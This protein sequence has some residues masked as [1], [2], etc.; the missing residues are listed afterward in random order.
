MVFYISYDFTQKKS[1][2]LNDTNKKQ[3]EVEESELYSEESEDLSEFDHARI[4]LGFVNPRK[5]ELS[6]WKKQMDFVVKHDLIDTW[7]KQYCCTE[8]RVVADEYNGDIKGMLTYSPVPAAEFVSLCIDKSNFHIHTAAQ[9]RDVLYIILLNSLDRHPYVYQLYRFTR[10]WIVRFLVNSAIFLVHLSLG[11][12]KENTPALLQQH[13]TKPWILMAEGVVLFIELFE[14]ISAIIILRT[15]KRGHQETYKAKIA[16]NGVEYNEYLARTVRGFMKAKYL[17][18]L[19]RLSF[20]L[21][22]LIIVTLDWLAIM[23]FSWSIEYY[24][25]IRVL[26]PFFLNEAI[27]SV[28]RNFWNTIRG[29]K[30]EFLLYFSSVVFAAITA[31]I[32]FRTTL[33]P[34]QI[35]NSYRNIIRSITTSFVFFSTGENYTELVYSAFETNPLYV[36]YYVSVTIM[37]SFIVGAFVLSSFVS[38]FTLEFQSEMLKAKH[39]Q[40]SGLIASFLLLDVSHTSQ[41]PMKVLKEFYNRVNPAKAHYSEDYLLKYRTN[42]SEFVR[43]CRDLRSFVEAMEDLIED[44]RIADYNRRYYDPRPSRR[45]SNTM[46]CDHRDDM[47]VQVGHIEPPAGEFFADF[48]KDQRIKQQKNKRSSSL[49]SAAV[50]IDALGGAIGRKRANLKAKVFNMIG[51]QITAQVITFFVILQAVLL[52][53]Y[54]LASYDEILD[55]FNVCLICIYALELIIKLYAFGLKAYLTPTD[56]QFA[57]HSHF[58]LPEY[59]VANRIDFFAIIFSVGSVL[60]AIM[61]SKGL[62]FS[63][64][65]SLRFGMAFSVIRIF[66]QVSTMRRLLYP[67]LVGAVLRQFANLFVLL[68][69]VMYVF[70]YYGML[71]FHNMFKYYVLLEDTPQGTFDSLTRSFLLLFQL[72]VGEVG[73]FSSQDIANM[74]IGMARS[75]VCRSESSKGVRGRLVLYIVYCRCDLV[76]YQYIRVSGSRHDGEI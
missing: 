50:K 25:P 3:S 63:G 60:V 30:A 49:S 39:Y 48:E 58:N 47:S 57:M 31:S 4:K 45:M 5:T 6:Y 55:I 56:Y 62:D 21:V 61:V 52:T 36:I 73:A 59:Q 53:F 54:G 38:G 40:R 51:Y 43:K 7:K 67:I 19:K 70:A 2:T 72:L 37:G 27:R 16:E 12:A 23:A 65:E 42:R 29:A 46:Q 18:H 64:H 66:S 34:D 68:L 11:I 22:L 74:F 13:G 8:T 26:I 32:L 69:L 20:C 44:Q 33:N 15:L 76:V 14:T 24:I 28:T 9:N 17:S 10:L 71:L 41:I 1:K 75:N 35:E